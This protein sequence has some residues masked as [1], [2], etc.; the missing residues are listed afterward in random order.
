VG[1][2]EENPL[3]R[4]TASGPPCDRRKANR[5]L[6]PTP[7]RYHLAIRRFRRIAHGAHT[8]FTKPKTPG[9]P[10]PVL[11]PALALEMREQVLKHDGGQGRQVRANAVVDP[12]PTFVGLY[13]IRLSQHPQL[14]GYLILGHPQRVD[15]LADACPVWLITQQVDYAEALFVS[16]RS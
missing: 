15:E 4:L 1:T 7:K 8:A 13:K 14:P 16:Q 12:V 11:A 3:H 2:H 10:F 5:F 6:S 9:E